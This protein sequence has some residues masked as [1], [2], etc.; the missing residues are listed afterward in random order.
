MPLS[1]FSRQTSM[2]APL[3]NYVDSVLEPGENVRYRTNVSRTIY[4]PSILLAVC[5][6]A[7]LIVGANH[8]ETEEFFWFFAIVCAIAAIGAFI[9]AWFRRSTTEIA[10]TDRRIILKRGFIRRATLEMNLQKVESVDVDQT[11]LGRLFDFGS[12]TIRGTGST[13][14]T[15]SMIDS[16]LKLRT[17]V[18]AG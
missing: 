3:M 7:V 14:E 6:A 2:E 1:T 13:F 16:P 18:T 9:P 12:V 4:T 15:L 5:A 11:L 10:V 8:R 17:T